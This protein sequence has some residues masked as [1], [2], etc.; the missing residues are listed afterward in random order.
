MPN[1]VIVEDDGP[2][3]VMRLHRPEK[4]NALTQPMYA[5]LT[6]SLRD[7]GDSATIG[8]LVI[9][10]GPGAF[11]AGHDIGDFLAGADDG[12][13]RTTQEFLKILARNQKPLVAAVTGLAVGVGTTM[14]LHCDHV[15]AA[16]EAVFSTPFGKLGLVPEAASSLLAPQRLGH[17][18]AFA[19]LVMGRPLDAEEAKDA[20]L[21]NAVTEAAAVEPVALKAAHEIAALP[22]AAVLAARKLLRGDPD[23][24]GQRIDTEIALFRERLQS[25]EARAAFSAFLGRKG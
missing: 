15:V 10:G 7:A 25:A 3:R 16:R 12:L 21:V 5:A 20:G 6:Q 17:A 9:A 14:L 2:V 8:C 4:K 13:S 22:R 23:A 18:R 1:S 24:I 11:C 19:L